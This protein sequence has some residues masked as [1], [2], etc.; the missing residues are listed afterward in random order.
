ML[1]YFFPPI[2]TTGATRS[3]A[4]GRHLP[5]FGW[6]PQ[7]LTVRD[8]KDPWVKTGAPVPE[9]IEIIRTPEWNLNAL[10]SI[11][12]G[13]ISKACSLFGHDLKRD[14]PREI[15]CLPDSQMAWLSTWYGLSA[16]KNSDCIYA[17][18]SPFSSAISGTWLKKLTGKPLVLDFRDPW[19]LNPHTSPIWFHKQGT[20]ILERLVIR[21]CDRLILN[22]PGAERLYREKYPQ[23]QDKFLAIPNGYDE[24]Q[25][26][27]AKQGE[28]KDAP[29]KIMHVGNFYGARNPD[30]LLE[31]LTRL[32]RSDIEFVQVGGTFPSYEHYKSRLSITVTGMVSREEALKQMNTASL[33]FLKQGFEEGVDD[34]VAVAAKTYEYLACGLP[35]IADCPEGDNADIIREYGSGS[36]V[37]CDNQI[38]SVEQAVRKALEEEGWKRPAIKESFKQAFDRKNLSKLL[39]ETLSAACQ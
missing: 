8:H 25:L 32:E 21:N 9:G 29:L 20:E 7:I 11:L 4:F 22:T 36:H 38:D 26:V 10:I 27:E 17:T 35:V 19:T 3:I 14:Y 13:A 18:C 24:L 31:A 23:Y 6:T 39:A 28:T 2:L 5:A 12:N 16:A 30:N 33:L 1:C 34:Y 15:L 37:V